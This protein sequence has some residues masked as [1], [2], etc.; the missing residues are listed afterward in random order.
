MRI[1]AWAPVLLGIC[2][3]GTCLGATDIERHIADLDSPVAA[4]RVQAAAALGQAAD[5]EGVPQLID[6]LDDP[7]S[8][9][10]REAAKALGLIKDERAAASLARALRD[11]DPNVR[12]YAAYALGEIKDRRATAVLL[13][14]LGDPEWCVR[15]QAA[16]ALR[17]L[18][19]PGIVEPLAAMLQKKDA[20]VPHILWL[21]QQTGGD[22]AIEAIASLMS[23]PNS[24]SRLLAVKTLIKYDDPRKADWLIAALGDSNSAVR[25]LALDELVKLRDERAKE[26]LERLAA[27]DDDAAVREA[28]QAGVM[29]LSREPG[30]L[31]WWNFDDGG[32]LVA[33]DV[34]GLG[35]DGRIIGCTPVDGKIGKALQFGAGKY[36]EL[37]KPA[38]LP[39]GNKPMT[40]MAWVKTSQ[41]NGV[42]V[43]RGGAFCGYSLYIKDGVAK[44]GIHREQEGPGYIAAGTDQVL[45]SWV[46]LAGVIKKDRIELY[47]NGELAAVEKTAGFIPGNCGQGMEIG[48]DVSNSAAEISD[49]LEGVIDEVRQYEI[50]LTEPQIA[51]HAGHTT[52]Q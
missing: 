7:E 14:A 18:R 33:K 51:E 6:A 27:E 20:D 37:G 9:V 12:M 39:I 41:P 36:I 1:A 21:L 17:E 4:V 50:P 52:E 29:E 28:A 35:N 25:R 42:V 31:A 2:T 22:K 3:S 32:T 47:V 48:F 15:D 16:W 30:I 46:H 10:R 19:E 5:A 34:T 49:P 24:E 43:G 40:I 8:D 45:G 11:N 26:P 23:V 44:F 13:A 38:G